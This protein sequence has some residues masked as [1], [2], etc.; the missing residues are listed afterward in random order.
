[1][2]ERH[3]S[4]GFSSSSRSTRPIASSG[5]SI[6]R[7]GGVARWISF[8]PSAASRPGFS[9][10]GRR[11]SRSPAGWR[12]G[13]RR[14]F[15]ATAFQAAALAL[16]AIV[17]PL[18]G[19]L[20]LSRQWIAQ[21]AVRLRHAG[22]NVRRLFRRTRSSGR[23]CSLIALLFALAVPGHADGRDRLS[24]AGAVGRR[25]FPGSWQCGRWARSSSS[26]SCLGGMRAAAFV[27]VLQALLFARGVVAV[28]VI[29]W[30]ELGGFGSFVDLLAKLGASKVGD[31]GASTDGYNA[32][33]R[34]AR[35]RPIRRGFRQGGAGRRR[36]DDIDGLCRRP[37]R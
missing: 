20:V 5:A 2:I 12:S 18:A 13:C 6:A 26:M 22:G 4:A 17:I 33:S 35:R 25:L 29:A 14:R 34:N 15:S 36:V 11:R 19:A 10:R 3:G 28:G 27:G 16:G 31:W 24:A 7:A 9:R 8:L 30:V 21:P 32:L 1:M 37:R 23:S